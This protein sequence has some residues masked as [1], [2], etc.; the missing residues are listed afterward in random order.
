MKPIE[1]GGMRTA[2]RFEPGNYL[3]D[4]HALERLIEVQTEML[5]YLRQASS[6][7]IQQIK[8]HSPA[9]RIIRMNLGDLFNLLLNHQDRHWKQALIAME[10]V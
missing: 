4:M 1:S 6:L 3:S 5:T 7:D 9:S 8:V 2:R 10:S